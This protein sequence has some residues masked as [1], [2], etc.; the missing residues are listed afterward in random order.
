MQQVLD[1]STYYD[2]LEMVARDCRQCLAQ[3]MTVLFGPDPR[4]DRFAAG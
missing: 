2:Y 4:I 1:F 3:I